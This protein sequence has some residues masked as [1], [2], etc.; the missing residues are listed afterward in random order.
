[1]HIFFKLLSWLSHLLNYPVSIVWN[2]DVDARYAGAGAA[3]SPRDQPHDLELTG[4]SLANERRTSVTLHKT[5][6]YDYQSRAFEAK[7]AIAI[8]VYSR[9]TLYG[10]SI[11]AGL[12]AGAHEA[13][14]V[15]IVELTESCRAKT[16]LAVRL[17]HYGDVDFLQH[18]LVVA[19]RTE[20]V[21]APS[22]HPA[23]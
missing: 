21:L 1:M 17:T 16:V 12:A 15:E 3:D 19:R 14:P 9:K 7:A 13:R 22:R 8:I 5:F 10:A 23:P 11:F 20:C 4:A 6:Q 2:V 18:A